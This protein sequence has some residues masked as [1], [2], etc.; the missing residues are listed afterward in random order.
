MDKKREDSDINYVMLH[1][2]GEAVAKKI[3]LQYLQENLKSIL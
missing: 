1:K 2:I 3:P